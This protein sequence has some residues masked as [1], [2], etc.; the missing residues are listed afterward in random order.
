MMVTS[1]S[2]NLGLDI[3][4]LKKLCCPQVEKIGMLD[5]S[6]IYLFFLYISAH[7]EYYIQTQDHFI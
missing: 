7:V 5:Q 1:L 2:S 6:F 3:F 4:D